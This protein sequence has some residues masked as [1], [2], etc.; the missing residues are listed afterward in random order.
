[1][2]ATTPKVQLRGDVAKPPTPAFAR[3]VLLS[4]IGAAFFGAAAWFGWTWWSTA[5]FIKSTDDA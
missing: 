3:N 5:R 1:M 4:V 2:D